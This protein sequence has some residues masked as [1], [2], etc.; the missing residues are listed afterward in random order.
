MSLGRKHPRWVRGASSSHYRP[1]PSRQKLQSPWY[2]RGWFK[3]GNAGG[4]HGARWRFESARWQ[5]RL[6]T[7]VRCDEREIGSNGRFGSARVRIIEP[8]AAAEP[9][10]VGQGAYKLLVCKGLRAC[11]KLDLMIIVFPATH[12]FVFRSFA[13]S[14]RFTALLRPFPFRRWRVGSGVVNGCLPASVTFRSGLDG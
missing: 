2:F 10:R 14:G 13:T 4:K 8:D 11:E 12:F 7:R 3:R 6:C 5:L 9:E 1:S